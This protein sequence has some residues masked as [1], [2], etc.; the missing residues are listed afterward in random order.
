MTEPNLQAIQDSVLDKMEHSARLMR[1]AILVAALFEAI[2]IGSAL[3][4]TDWKD[5]Q[6]I[7]L[8]VYFVSSYTI[9]AMGMVAVG[10]HMTRCAGRVLAALDT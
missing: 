7:L 10:A 5:R 6:Q 2:L 4:L 9:M 3:L 8:F 1:W